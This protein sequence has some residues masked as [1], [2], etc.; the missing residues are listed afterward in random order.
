MRKATARKVNGVWLLGTALIVPEI[1]HRDDYREI[2][3]AL[4]VANFLLLFLSF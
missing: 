2:T 3:K 1:K 4:I